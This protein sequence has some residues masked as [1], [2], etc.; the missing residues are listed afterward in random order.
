MLFYVDAAI[1]PKNARQIQRVIQ[2]K[3]EVGC[4]VWNLWVWDPKLTNSKYVCMIKI[5]KRTKTNW[6][7]QKKK[8]K[9]IKV[10]IY[11][12]A[13]NTIYI[14]YYAYIYIYIYAFNTIYI[15]QDIL[16]LSQLL[17]LQLFK[18]KHNDSQ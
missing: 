2:G 16:F 7:K 15:K 9:G 13:F 12:S 3:I 4:Q 5:N 17:A 6:Q 1:K 8:K 10:N 18:V 14:I 11:K